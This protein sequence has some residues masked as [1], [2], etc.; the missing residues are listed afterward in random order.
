MSLWFAGT[1]G[2]I[3]RASL[4]AQVMARKV[5]FQCQL[6]EGI[7]LE[8]ESK[9]WLDNCEV[10]GSV[11][12]GI[13]INPGCKCVLTRTTIDH[14]GKGDASMPKGQGGMETVV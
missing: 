2:G 14:C 8:H 9:L 7:N 12:A 5:H 1:D 10:V 6:R 11:G 13:H 3:I 4:S